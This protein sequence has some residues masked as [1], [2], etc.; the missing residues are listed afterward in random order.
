MRINPKS[1]DNCLEKRQKRSKH[2]DTER[3]RPCE[4]RSRDWNYAASSQE[5]P[6]IAS[7][8]QNREKEMERILPQSVS[9]PLF[10]REMPG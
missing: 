3:G 10:H 2:G 5:T 6:E 4:Y 1:N 7:S 8:Y 9:Q